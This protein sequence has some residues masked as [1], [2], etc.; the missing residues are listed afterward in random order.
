MAR[1]SLT[2]H[3]NRHALQW[4]EQLMTVCALRCIRRYGAVAAMLALAA[5]T[6]LTALTGTTVR[7]VADPPAQIPTTP[8]T[9]APVVTTTTSI[10]EFPLPPSTTTSIGEFPLP[11]STTTSI[12]EFPLPPS[13][14]TSIGEFPLPPSTTT[15]TTTRRTFA[16]TEPPPVAT[17]TTGPPPLTTSKLPALTTSPFPVSVPITPESSGIW[18]LALLFALAGAV[19]VSAG[20]LTRA[21]R[22]RRISWVK[23]HVTV[24]TEHAGEP[25]FSTRPGDETNRDLILTVIPVEI[26]R[27]TTLEEDSR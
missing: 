4:R 25:T 8:T 14:T 3:T 18:P 15:T 23:E 21:H 12:G 6:W 17:T 1:E 13:T 10:G 24:T 9:E 5:A 19:L 27:T 11:P 7:A 16:T 22:H 20:L 2:S 26:L